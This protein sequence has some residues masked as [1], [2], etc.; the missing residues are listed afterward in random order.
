M[1][2][3]LQVQRFSSLSPRLEHGSIQVGVVQEE[4]SFYTFF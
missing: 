1:G 4:L 2:A 3:G